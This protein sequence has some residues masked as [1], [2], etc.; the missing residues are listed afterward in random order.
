MWLILS[1]AEAVAEQLKFEH[2]FN[3]GSAGVGEGE[4]QY[5]EDF[6]FSKEGDLL[7]TDASHACEVKL[8]AVT[9]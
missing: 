8:Q 9:R 2:L 7:I 3:I 5:A 4:F 1:S 6:A